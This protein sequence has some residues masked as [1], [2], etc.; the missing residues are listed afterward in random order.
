MTTQGELTS[1]VWISQPDA[2]AIAFAAKLTIEG[3]PAISRIKMKV[4]LNQMAALLFDAE[5]TGAVMTRSLAAE[6]L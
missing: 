3:A 1:M 2:S 5:L 6:Q 4:A